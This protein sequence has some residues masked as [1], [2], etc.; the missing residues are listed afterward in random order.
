VEVEPN[1]SCAIGNPQSA[2]IVDIVNYG[3]D[4]IKLLLILAGT[5]QLNKRA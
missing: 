5:A 3:P 2:A 1:T 4:T